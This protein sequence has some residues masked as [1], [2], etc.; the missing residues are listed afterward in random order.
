[1]RCN[2]GQTKGEIIS[3]KKQWWLKIR[4]KAVRLGPADGAIFPYVVK[5][6]YCAEG[7]EYLRKKW[8]KASQKPPLVGDVVVIVYQKQNPKKFKVILNQLLS[9]M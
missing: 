4:T 5:I 3:A 6:K 9:E 2:V 8:I 7:K 1:M